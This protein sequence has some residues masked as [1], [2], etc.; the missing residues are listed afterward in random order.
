MPGNPTPQPLFPVG[1]VTPGQLLI[2][3]NLP[4]EQPSPGEPPSDGTMSKGI[5]ARIWSYIEGWFKDKWDGA[6]DFFG[7]L[8]QDFKDLLR[9]IVNVIDNSGRPQT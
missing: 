9:R 4:P 5:F 3:T 2:A 6:K 1:S 8:V 7:D